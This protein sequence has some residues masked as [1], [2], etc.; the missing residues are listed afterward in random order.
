MLS[1]YKDGLFIFPHAW[2]IWM[3]SVVLES[4]CSPGYI[5][6]LARYLQHL[7]KLI[8]SPL[9]ASAVFLLL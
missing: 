7:S 2:N 6:A 8:P 5:Q 9:Q 4:L 3:P 1:L